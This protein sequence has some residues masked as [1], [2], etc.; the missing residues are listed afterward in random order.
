MNMTTTGEGKVVYDP[1][2]WHTANAIMHRTK[3]EHGTKESFA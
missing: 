1:F 3:A 2:K